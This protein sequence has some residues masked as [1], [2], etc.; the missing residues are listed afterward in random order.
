IV[1]Q[2]DVPPA[3]VV[4]E[5]IK[6]QRADA[7]KV[8]EM[9][10]DVFEK[11]TTTTTTT[12][13]APG[14]RPV[15]PPTN[16]PV[17]PVQT[18]VSVEGDLS[19]FAA[20]SEDSIVVGKIK[21]AADVRTN[22]THVITRPVNMPFI[23]KLISEFDANVEFAKPVTRPLR[24]ISAS[25]VLPVLVQALTEPG[26]QQQGG[27][28]GTGGPQPGATTQRTPSPTVTNPYNA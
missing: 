13:V 15:R 25:D 14:V 19:A 4:S 12:T 23:R 7:S 24:Y 11:G 17:Q 1:D 2:I 27:A 8:V 9:L 26:E 20:L 6:L 28:G 21:I 3:Q 18:Q 10:K 5:F 22:R 16:V